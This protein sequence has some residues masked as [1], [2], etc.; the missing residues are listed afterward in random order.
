MTGGRSC[1]WALAAIVAASAVLR[2]ALCARGGQYFFGDEL[3]YDRAVQLY[4]AVA[5]HDASAIR[6]ILALPDHA[7][8]TC[9]GALVTAA[10]RLLAVATPFGDWSHHPENA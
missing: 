6:E 3:R 9:L 10:Q 7:L 2:L 4:F 5:N 1:R 8:F